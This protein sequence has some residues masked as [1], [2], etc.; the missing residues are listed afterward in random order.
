VLV[1]AVAATRRAV[2]CAGVAAALVAY[3]AASVGSLWALLGYVD[4]A[5]PYLGYR[6]PLRDPLRAGQVARALLPSGGQ[7]LVADDHLQVEVLRFAIGY[8][9]PSRIFDDCRELPQ[10]PGAVYLLTSEQ[11][12]G[13]G[14]LSESGAP[15][16]ARIE[17]VGDAYRVYGA[18]TKQP[19][20]D[21][22]QR[23]PEYESEQCRYR[24]AEARM[25]PP[26]K[27]RRQQVIS[28]LS[29]G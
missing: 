17:R 28:A 16:L 6:I 22:L 7:I 11:T 19:D 26:P 18:P 4:R 3:A 21:D 9:V 25:Y 15:L 5:N 14:I 10:V 27:I 29:Q 8:E 12:P 2:V 24:R 13:A 23:R 20:V 1:A